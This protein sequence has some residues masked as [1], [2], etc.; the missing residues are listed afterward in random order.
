VLNIKDRHNGNIL[1]D[2]RGHL[3]HIDFGFLL[4][5]SPGGNLGFEAGFKL[6]AEYIA[7]L[8]GPRGALFATY[9]KLCVRAFLALRQQRARVILL[10]QMTMA[11]NEGLPCFQGGAR[12][13]MAG[14]RARFREEAG[15]N[16]REVVAFVNRL[17][18]ANMGSWRTSVYDAIQR[19]SQGV[20]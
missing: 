10:V 15:D 11:G 7:V 3:L 14:L 16:E 2:R 1:L 17:I 18:D 5:N 13:V 20:R 8:G 12:A 9:R 6:T 19:Y 4:T